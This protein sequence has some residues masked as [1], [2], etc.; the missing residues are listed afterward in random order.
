MIELIQAVLKPCQFCGNNNLKCFDKIT[1]I[2]EWFL[3]KNK[4]KSCFIHC[5]KCGVNGPKAPSVKRAIE[6]WNRRSE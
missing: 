1:E 6:A 4:I 2:R 3:V 5:L